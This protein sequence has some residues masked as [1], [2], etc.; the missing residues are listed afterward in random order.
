V[1]DNEIKAVFEILLQERA[2]F[3]SALLAEV[4]RLGDPKERK[5]TLAAGIHRGLIKAKASFKGYNKKLILRECERGEH[6]AM[7][8]YADALAQP[9]PTELHALVEKQYAKVKEA[10]DTICVLQ[11]QMHKA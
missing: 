11:G 1:D 2:Q 7:K 3:A 9:L 6:M 4:H 10:H 5:G 8:H